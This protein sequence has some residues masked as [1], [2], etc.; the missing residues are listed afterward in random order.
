[1]HT[2]STLSVDGQLGCYIILA[3][4]TDAV[5]K[6][7]KATTFNCVNILFQLRNYGKGQKYGVMAL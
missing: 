2:K 4:V 7:F 5:S 6:L 1:M 3:T